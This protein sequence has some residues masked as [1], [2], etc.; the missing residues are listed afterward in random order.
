MEAYVLPAVLLPIA[1][2]EDPCTVR[3]G[4]EYDVAVVTAT[5]IFANTMLRAG[6]LSYLMQGIV[7]YL[8]ALNG[9]V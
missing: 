5:G 6:V 1:Y 4:T 7:S 9:V 8:N 2:A 3:V